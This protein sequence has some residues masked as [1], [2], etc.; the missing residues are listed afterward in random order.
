[1]EWVLDNWPQIQRYALQ[2]LALSLPPLI[3]GVI[4]AVP[5]GWIAARYRWSR[6]ALLGTAGVLYAIPSLPL[7]VVLPALIGTRILD[8]LNV[9][10]A[11][12]LYAIALMVRTSADAF[13]AVS[14]EL[15][16]SATA[17]GFSGPQRFFGAELPAAAPTLLAG[18]RVVAVSTVSLV[19]VGALIG[20]QSLGYFFVDG[21]QRAFPT[22]IL[23]GV[24]GTVLIALLLDALLVVA[25]R[26]LMPWTRVTQRGLA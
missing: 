12:T 7:F 16:V 23:V 4:V 10:A 9:V 26:L 2:H 8:P 25:G 3:I 22:E 24:I 19:T 17:L 15:R 20:V 18:A 21:Y 1:M 11:L 14:P 5:L 13:A 6:G